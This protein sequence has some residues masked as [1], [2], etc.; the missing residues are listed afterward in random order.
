M[1]S[2][3]LKYYEQE[4]RF[5]K[6]EGSKF[7]EKHPKAAKTLGLNKQGVAD[8]ELMMLIESFA[9]LN[10]RLQSSLDDTFPDFTNGLLELFFPHYVKPLPSY[11]LLNFDL[12]TKVNASHVIPKGT[13]FNIHVNTESE[14]IFRSSEGIVIHPIQLTNVTAEFAPFNKDSGIDNEQAK[15]MIELQLNTLD[16]DTQFNELDINKIK[17]QLR[18]E[19]SFI[20]RLYDSIYNN[21]VETRVVADGN[22]FLLSKNKISPVGFSHEEII[23]P[24]ESSSLDGYNI[25]T[26]FFAYPERFYAFNVELGEVIQHLTDS[27]IKIQLLLKELD[28]DVKRLID[29]NN[30]SIF[31]LPIVN[32]HD[33]TA[34]PME[35][36]FLK[37]EHEII[38]DSW[39]VESHNIYSVNNVFDMTVSKEKVPKIFE[40]KFSNSTSNYR[41]QLVRN[42]LELESKKRYL[43]VSDLKHQGDFN[44]KRI[45]LIKTTVSQPDLED[46]VNQSS[47][48]SCRE[49][50]TIPADITLIERPTKSQSQQENDES[51]W[52]LLNHLHKN[53][54]SI[55]DA[56]DPVYELKIVLS[57]YNFT[58]NSLNKL[59]IESIVNLSQ[60]HV[61]ETIR[62]NGK[63]CFAFG[64]QITITLS[65]E[66]LF[67]GLTLFSQML[68]I[69][70]SQFA[71]FNSF[72][73]VHILIDGQEGV[74]I[75]F[76]RE[77]GCKSSI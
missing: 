7:V 72:I 5:V 43:K 19:N 30:I 21:R 3:L 29:I 62:L 20:L 50:F 44:E 34:E 73:Q 54:Q 39:D 49:S 33:V 23:L 32:L 15:A 24:E 41:W 42:K 8:P 75:S 12:F 28:V 27:E 46:K 67:F 55:F 66:A 68:N 31:T 71:G 70:F 77:F 48:V 16:E 47:Q 45:W 57:Y 56:K 6:N 59:M 60:D 69:Y 51:I 65:N 64:T 18:G 1:F 9:F 52:T 25:L 36:D 76:P 13:E 40:H 74:Y 11:S 37:E 2:T 22:S 10:A 14:M 4:L 17:L 63:N 38:I 53:Y 61:V 35:I 26:E 58:E